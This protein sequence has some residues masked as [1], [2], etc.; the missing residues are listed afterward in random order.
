MAVLG[1]FEKCGETTLS[2]KMRGLVQALAREFSGKS[3]GHCVR[4]DHLTATDGIQ[5][6]LSLRRLLAELGRD[7]DVSTYVLAHD[8]QDEVQIPAD[9]A[10]ELR[11]RKSSSL[12]LFVPASLQD[13]AVSSLGN[14]FSPFDLPALL[15]RLAEELRCD[16]PGCIEAEVNAALRQLRGSAR[17]PV[18]EVID[19]YSA[20]LDEPD[21][22]TV[23]R[24]LWRIGLIPDL[25]QDLAEFC[26][27]VELNRK[28]VDA[29]ARPGRPY[30]SVAERVA[31]LK[32]SP[33]TI[34]AKLTQYL[35]G[36]RLQSDRE[37]LRG[38]L[39]DE[40]RGVLTFEQWQF[41]DVE[42]SD[43]ESITLDP[44]YTED[45]VAKGSGLTMDEPGTVPYARCGDQKFVAVK[46]KSDPARPTDVAQWRVEIIPDRDEYDPNDVDVAGVELPQV[47]VRGSVRSAKVPLEIDPTALTVRE[48]Q[49]RV[50]ALDGNGSEIRRL[51]GEDEGD[52][53]KEAKPVEGL[54]LRFYLDVDGADP[55]PGAVKQRTLPTERTL[56]DALLRFCLKAKERPTE[57]TPLDPVKK[58]QVYFPYRIGERAVARVSTT[59][60]LESLERHA[61]STFALGGRYHTVAYGVDSLRMDNVV[62]DPIQVEEETLRP[63]WEKFNRE[64]R[65]AFNSIAAQLGGR[66]VETANVTETLAKHVR[67]YARAYCDLIDA[68]LDSAA[69]SSPEGVSVETLDG[70][71]GL[72]TLTIALPYLT[73][74][75]RATVFLPTHP[76][77]LL[78][79]VAYA[80]WVQKI[81][82]DL[83]RAPQKQRERLFNVKALAQLAPFNI[84]ALYRPA[85]GG[86]HGSQQVP[87]AEI[88]ADNLNF[89]WAVTLPLSAED[90]GMLLS[91]VARVLGF[92][93]YQPSLTNLSP[94]DAIDEVRSYLTLHP[95]LRTLRVNAVN[96]GSGEFVRDVF[97]NALTAVASED[98]GAASEGYHLDL[99]TH[100]GGE[101]QTPTD[102][103][104]ALTVDWYRRVLRR[105]GNHLQPSIQVARRPLMRE[106]L[107]DL[108]GGDVHL[109]LCLDYFKPRLGLSNPRSLGSNGV[110]ALEGAGEAGVPANQTMETSAAVFGLLT[111]FQTR[112]TSQD[113]VAVWERRV[114]FESEQASERHPVNRAYSDLLVEAQQG[115]LRLLGLRVW[116]MAEAE[117][118]T[119][120]EQPPQWHKG[121]LP[122]LKLE[123]TPEER[124]LVNALHAQSDWV[125]TIDRHFGV[126]YFDTPNDA[127]LGGQARQYLLDYTP[128]FVDGLGHRLVVTTQWKEE[129]I[130]VLG[131][132]MAELGLAC[133]PESCD[134]MLRTLKMISSRLALRLVGDSA[135]GE[136]A[137]STLAK[138]T[139]SLAVVANYLL[140]QGELSNAVLVPLDA[141]RRLFF[142]AKTAYL[143]ESGSRC[144]LLIV[145]PT[146][147]RLQVDFVEVKYR[148]GADPI[149]PNLLAQIADQTL[150]TDKAVRTMYF[151]GERLDSPILRC[152]FAAILRFYAQRAMRH[153]R[154][155]DELRYA[156]LLENIARVEMGLVKLAP[157]YRG[158][159][160]NLGGKA[161]RLLKHEDV[162][163]NV[164]TGMEIEKGTS[165]YLSST[166]PAVVAETAGV[167]PE[168]P[169]AATSARSIAESCPVGMPGA[170]EA[171]ASE[172]NKSSSPFPSQVAV[173]STMVSDA[174]QLGGELVVPLGVDED[175]DQVV[176]WV[177]SVKGSPHLFVMGIPG[178][179]KSWG[180]LRLISEVSRRGVPSLILDFHGQFADRSTPFA[181]AAQP[182][183]LS[184]TD[185][186]PFSPFEVGMRNGAGGWKV[187]AFQVSEILQY[188]CDLGDMQRD[189]VYEAIHDAYVAQGF[190]EDSPVAPP[191]PS[192]GQ[193]FAR[194]KELEGERKGIKNT[195]ARVRPLFEFDL[196]GNAGEA[197]LEDA[198]DAGGRDFASLFRQTSVVDLHVVGMET[199]QIAAGAFVLRKLYKDMFAWGETERL[200]LLVVLDEAH[201]LARDITLPKLM[202]EGRKFGVAIVVASQTMNDFHP[203]VLQNAG[204]KILYRT[205]FP[206]SKKAAGYMKAPHHI[207]DVVARLEQLSVGHALIQTPEMACCAEVSMYPYK[208]N[209][210][211]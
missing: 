202:K 60:F 163:I 12:C 205:N 209:S 106:M 193:V 139:V 201:R 48:V 3:P 92:E 44:L 188:V 11:N 14:S 41:P 192:V 96:P 144:D 150:R 78:W 25:T 117:R 52:D 184:V 175:T 108:P 145:R 33:N 161:Q 194:L 174:G 127:Y 120:G 112:F 132:A 20:V 74:N 24:E 104:E 27:R 62:S 180:V 70:V 28:C 72:D 118:P 18:E 88:F 154:V 197:G 128:E 110:T 178:Q 200:R 4:V 119:G 73:G 168:V 95:Y 136:V 15:L 130:D 81:I 107:E 83:W 76:L 155:T 146:R 185:G 126:E 100:S 125:L 46:W 170:N 94:S 34:Q 66:L 173:A 22:E 82:E 172:G 122:A 109:S 142:D 171:S 1:Y 16:L 121:T 86:G 156:E 203:E 84:P 131:Q 111:H 63:L 211:G 7:G 165:F 79:H 69:G 5:A 45:T 160:V 191:L 55:E 148:Q 9:R 47:I 114:A 93:E 147:Q 157:R 210:E 129:V 91:E 19:Y 115:Y 183:V 38:L 137:Q 207:V 189:L 177:G 152:Q 179:G 196:F 2:R 123:V 158:F 102:G 199:L 169:E 187:N 89:F 186:L 85:I 68:A 51:A 54:S 23:G 13:A 134:E 164:L 65:T 49:V 143:A 149:T 190:G 153:G 151:D 29:M 77:R 67:A 124:H 39:A 80:E 26:R 208:D 42:P 98:Q 101:I 30:S 181:Q 53:A 87:E 59:L 75:P 57:V 162:T 195:V 17:V 116:R 97:G 43:L 167:G 35:L 90:P 32:L 99:I 113:G 198:C 8:E 61:L 31:T 140:T 182:N 138:E 36:R 64:R 133:D 71:L 141:H 21:L 50:T 103:L 204:T 159:V 6:C 37:W 176:T 135:G 40:C 58:D 166:P 10:I 105:R 56:P 206:Q